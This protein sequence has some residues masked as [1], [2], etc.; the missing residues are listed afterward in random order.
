MSERSSRV[1]LISVFITRLACQLDRIIKKPYNSHISPSVLD[2][3]DNDL[4]NG[5]TPCAENARSLL[6][7]VLWSF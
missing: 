4:M 3:I 6:I 7:E 2:I 1:L 5:A